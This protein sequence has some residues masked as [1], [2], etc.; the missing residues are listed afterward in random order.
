MKDYQNE[1][2]TKR[3][4]YL[5]SNIKI[6]AV[7][8]VAGGL[9]VLHRRKMDAVITILSEQFQADIQEQA[10]TVF[11]QGVMYGLQIACGPAED[12]KQIA[13]EGAKYAFSAFDKPA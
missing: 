12:A 6:G 2:Q 10:W 5:S 11:D 8:L 7:V 13:K 1:T 4:L 3:R 9:Y